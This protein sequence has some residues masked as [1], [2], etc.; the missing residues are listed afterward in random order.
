MK[1]FRILGL[2]L[3]AILLCLS[4]CSGGNDDP[5]EPAPKPEMPKSEITIDSSIISN[6]LSFSDAGGEQSISF[7][8]NEN[9]TLSVASTTSGTTWCTA[10][11][12]SGTKGSA[13][14]KFAVVENTTY[15]NR[16]V[17]VT[18][19]SGTASKTFTISQKGVDALLVTTD[20]YEVAQEGG[21]ISIEVKANINYQMEISET[22][23][24]WIK[25]SSSRAL[26]TY[27]HTLSIAANEETEKR[28][29]EIYFKSGDKVETVKIY[30]AGGAILLLTDNEYQVSDKGDTI[31]VDIKS[32]IEFGVQMPD[33]DWI[34][35]EASSRGLSS[36]TLKYIISANE[37]YDSR[38]AYIVFYDKNSDLKDTLVVNQAQKDAII[39]SKKDISVVSEGG[40][41]EV[42]V[43]SNVDFEV[44]IPTEATWIT[45]TDSRALV[46]N[47][48]YL[49]IAENTGEENRSAEIIFKNKSLSLSETVVITQKCPTPAG[50]NDGVLTIKTAGT[51]KQ[52]LGDNYLKITS[53]K[54]VGPINGDDVVCLR[55]MLGA[56]EFEETER[57]KLAGLDLSE[58]SIVEGGTWYYELSSTSERI[59]TSNDVIG[60]QMFRN[61]TT[62]ENIVLPNTIISIG[63]GAFRESKSLT[64]INIPAS[65]SFIDDL[66]FNECSSLKSI[67]IPDGVPSIGEWA[68]YNCSSLT[69]IVIP[70]SVTSIGKYAF[71]SCSS[72]ASIDIPDAVSF[73]GERAFKLCSSLT[74]I[75]IPNGVTSI[76]A[77]TFEGCI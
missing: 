12:T 13:S 72:L 54:I 59:Y 10:S 34:V 56:D 66:A 50:Y 29:G 8:T 74:S 19:K 33:V 7:S 39:L 52:L 53:L 58:A 28:E 47:S 15:D 18:I 77:C 61:C 69:S 6:G 25:E 60:N 23:K 71:R 9:W 31:S 65:V 36:H 21:T 2:A 41:I 38:S 17:S 55:Q 51:M 67:V 43:A 57:G 11:V 16:S 68:F 37:G 30:Q 1:T 48:V 24:D 63:R 35:D 14:V 73:I 45:Q 42:K 75:T 3:F 49:K 4:A 64:T 32:N 5:I 76:E 26:T 62:L 46:E 22:A 40:T 44:Q 27:N 70:S 20:K